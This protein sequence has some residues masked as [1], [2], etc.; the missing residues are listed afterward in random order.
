MDPQTA[1]IVLGLAAAAAWGSADFGGGLAGRRAALF[2]VVVFS[3][4]A[5]CGLAL[6]LAVVRGERVPGPPEVALALVAGVFGGI[7]IGA[8]YGGLA[9]GRMGVVAPIS[10]VLSAVVPVSAGI[11]LQG[12][13][14]PGA[15]AG[16]ALAI[17]AVVLV[18]AAPSGDADGTTG[19]PIAR[20]RGVP[21]DA[22]IAIVAGVALGLLSLVLSRLPAGSVF[23][24]LV[25][26][27]L[28]EATVVTSV[29]VVARRPWRLQRSVWLLVA[30]VGGLDMAGNALFVMAA[31]LGRLDIAAILSS[32]YPVATLALAAVVLKERI[33]G[34]HAIGV[35]AAIVA[36]VL[37]RV[38]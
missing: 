5:G 9:G 26:V 25:L 23:G 27:R 35:S 29:L 16:I 21:R 13:P 36:I 34:V 28:V 1:V 4:L 7:G 19:R 6:V 17:V 8:L 31:Q 3:L 20:I 11:L 33:A 2:G 37:V 30:V 18:S 22:L 32:L 10:G 24:P 15:L 14:G 38:G 12:L